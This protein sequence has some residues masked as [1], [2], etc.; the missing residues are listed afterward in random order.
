[1]VATTSPWTLR[2]PVAQTRDRLGAEIRTI[3]EFIARA[4]LLIVIDFGR[5]IAKSPTL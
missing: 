2:N 3:E 1:M 4:A 5:A